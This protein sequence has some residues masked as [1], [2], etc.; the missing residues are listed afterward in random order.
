MTSAAATA[1]VASPAGT[2]FEISL[3][4]QHDDADLRALLRDNPMSGSMQVTFEREP[5]F[6]AACSIRGHHCQVGI[7]R[8]LNSGRIVGLGTRSIAGAFINGRPAP[9]GWLS[10]LRLNPAY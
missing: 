4:T 5:D 7:G 2:R 1:A 8:D 3:A 10:D 9:F 6:F